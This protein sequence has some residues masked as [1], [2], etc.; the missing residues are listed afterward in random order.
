MSE[1]DLTDFWDT[2]FGLPKAQ[3]NGDYKHFLVRELKSKLKKRK[4]PITGVKSVL[5]NRLKT[6]DNL[7]Y[8]MLTVPELKNRMKSEG[9]DVSGDKSTLKSRMKTKLL[10][11][12]YQFLP[13][14]DLRLLCRERGLNL[15]KKNSTGQ[16]ST[17]IERL[18]RAD[19]MKLSAAKAKARTFS[20]SPSPS[21]STDSS[22][23]VMTVIGGV[24]A[25][26]LVLGCIELMDTD[27]DSYSSSSGGS[28]GSSSSTP[29]EQL[30]DVWCYSYS[31]DMCVYHDSSSN[32]VYYQ[33]AKWYGC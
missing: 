8:G 16:K 33:E 10:T 6:D 27:D 2:N 14:N 19:Q 9:L 24:I 4:L 11:R 7:G 25:F 31:L 29:C 22:P 5:I 30:K 18:G 20:Y 1:P 17:L 12:G 3:R 15:P 23:V 32:V 13:I 21:P 28:S 26:M